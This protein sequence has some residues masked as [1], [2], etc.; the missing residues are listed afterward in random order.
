MA[1]FNEIPRYL[2]A[3]AE[4]AACL[5]MSC[6]AKQRF[7][8]E[9]TALITVVMIALLCIYMIMTGDVA[10]WLWLICML[11]AVAIMFGYLAIVTDEGLPVAGYLCAQ[12]VLLAEFTAS[13]AW[14]IA[15]LLKRVKMPVF[16]EPLVILILYILCLY[17]YYIAERKQ[18]TKEFLHE[19]NLREVYTGIL[20]TA[21]AFALS[22]FIFIMEKNEYSAPLYNSIFLV[23]TIVDLCGLAIFAAYQSRINGY[24][25]L[26]EARTMHMMLKSQYDQYRY[27]ENTQE[28]IHIKYHDLK[29]QLFSLRA[30][31]D[32][33]KRNEWFDLLEKEIDENRLVDRT[34]NHVLDTILGAKIFSTQKINARVTCVADGKLLDFISVTDICAIFGNAMDNAIE[35]VACLA[36][37]QKRL[38]HVSV[39]SYRNFV[40]I[41]ISNYCGETLVV[42]PGEMPATTKADKEYHGY[43]LKSIAHRVE[44]YDGSTTIQVKDGWFELHIL[45]PLP[46]NRQSTGYGEDS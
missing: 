32:E 11:G 12:A 37:P 9:K 27:Y 18:Y 30:E 14:I 8:K 4:G 40:R 17:I 2:T 38:I 16:Y 44:K 24:L 28:M 35:S 46:E 7:S 31:T 6:F 33:K 26:Q 10:I 41:A 21:I 36:D 23:R 5:M 42:K 20:I 29:H 45:I 3:L 39:A 1:E 34:G 19:L 25:A 13:F 15:V 22:N 43:G